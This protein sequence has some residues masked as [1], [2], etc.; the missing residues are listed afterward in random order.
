MDLIRP[1]SILF[2]SSAF[3]YSPL[4][5]EVLTHFFFLNICS[6]AM[7]SKREP[8]AIYRNCLN[9]FFENL[10]FPSETFRATDVD[11]ASNCSTSL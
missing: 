7:V 4:Y 3:A 9:S 5:C 2:I 1:H 11:D 6:M 8:R 10:P